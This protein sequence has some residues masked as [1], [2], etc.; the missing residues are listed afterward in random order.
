MII[1]FNLKLKVLLLS[2]LVH[3]SYCNKIPQA[4]WLISNRNLFLTVLE[5]G[6]PGSGARVV[7]W[8]PVWVADVAEGARELSG[9]SVTRALIPFMR[10]QLPWPKH[11]L[12]APLLT[13]SLWGLG[14]QHVNFGW[15]QTFIQ[16]IAPSIS[17]VP[18]VFNLW[19]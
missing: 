3:S 7:R 11:P 5:A 10:V 14:F 4:R 8:G 16:T 9:R 13:L 17:I 6:R 15:T 19:R 2:V 18:M 12:K 1:N